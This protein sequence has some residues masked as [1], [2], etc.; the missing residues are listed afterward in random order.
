[1]N[2]WFT[3]SFEMFLLLIYEIE[4]GVAS[5]VLH[6]QG[7]LHKSYGDHASL[8]PYLKHLKPCPLRGTM[9]MT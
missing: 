7:G 4:G 3:M 1:M 9:T 2:W 5:K 8:G 6:H